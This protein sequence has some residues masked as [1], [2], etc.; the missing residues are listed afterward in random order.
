MQIND[1]ELD[2]VRR[3]EIVSS[4]MLGGQRGVT[5][6]VAFKRLAASPAAVWSV[7][8]DIDDY[9]N[10]MP[11]VKISEILERREDG[12]RMRLVLDTPFPL[13]DIESIYD[14]LHTRGEDFWKREWH[15]IDRG[16]FPNS[17]S[18]TLV[19]MP[20]NAAH[21]L[22]EYRV[23]VEP[24]LPVPKRIIHFAHNRVLPELFER[25]ALEAAKRDT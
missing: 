25:V 18:W 11:R 7:L 23:R 13:P 16:L 9:V 21:T 22:A 2:R 24:R 15:Q 5:E 6:M 17:G 1:A 4:L 12:L 20:D 14:S 19:P 10:T 8:D 3:G